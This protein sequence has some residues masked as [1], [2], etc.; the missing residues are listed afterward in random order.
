MWCWVAKVSW[1]WPKAVGVDGHSNDHR[2]R[3]YMMVTAGFDVSGDGINVLA[4]HS[5]RTVSHVSD[6]VYAALSAKGP[7]GNYVPVRF[8]A[9]R[10]S[11]STN[12]AQ[13]GSAWKRA[14]ARTP[15]LMWIAISA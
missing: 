9:G 2:N 11:S 4:M 1:P 6:T 7:N 5:F 3:Y 10:L 13:S 12:A 8:T 15:A 14:P